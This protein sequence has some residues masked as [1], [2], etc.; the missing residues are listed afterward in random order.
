MLPSI[1]L[2]PLLG[3]LRDIVLP[4]YHI[5]S[6]LPHLVC[7]MYIYLCILSPPAFFFD[8][9]V[10]TLLRKMGISRHAIIACYFPFIYVSCGFLP[11]MMGSMLHLI[12]F[13]AC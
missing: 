1:T 4:L 5:V 6:S 10:P 3:L 13:V 2:L 9:L 11:V 12:V 7:L 8:F